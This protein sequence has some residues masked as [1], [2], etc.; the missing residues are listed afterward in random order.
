MDRSPRILMVTSGYPPMAS[1]GLER[2][3]QRLA[4]ALAARGVPVTVLTLAGPGRPG[5]TSE[6]AGASVLH[7]LRPRGDGPLWGLTYMLEVARWLWRLRAR[8][9][10]VFCQQLYLHSVA[11][12]LVARRLGKAS[13]NLLV[14]ADSW[15]DIGR[16]RALRGGGAML[17]VAL[18]A[19]G[20]FAL[21]TRSRA[22]LLA[23]GVPPHRAFAF[24]YFVDLAAFSP[25]PDP[26]GDELLFLGR[27]DPQKNLPLLFEA[28]GQV[29]AVVPAARLRVVGQGPDEAVVRRLAA[30]ARTPGSV[31]VDPWTEDPAAAYRRARAVVSSSDSEG[32]S[33][34]MI[35]ALACGTPLVCTDVSGVRDAMGDP[36]TW[37]EPLPAG[38]F[39]RGM[40]GL[41]VNRGDA[42]GLAAAMLALLEEPDLGPLRRQ[43][44]ARAE[45]EYSEQT[46]VG[47]FL[48]D[49]QLLLERRGRPTPA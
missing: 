19:D 36:G 17:K 35:E 39:R 45:Q 33:N 25:G 41:V 18:S 22:E 9:D 8:W 6:D 32:L 42:E 46:C 20:Q 48:R 4:R 14:A 3:C 10:F 43:A 16:L 31:R 7:V 40:G 28:F 2:G 5:R 47:A 30:Q 12:A 23:S 29:Q 13:A 21:S 49:V 26:P 34:V 11:A 24:R 44:R 38:T 27:F 15:S 37:P 1:A